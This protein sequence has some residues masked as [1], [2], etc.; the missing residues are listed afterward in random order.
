MRFERWL[1]TFVGRKDVA[2]DVVDLAADDI[3]DKL[4]EI[5]PWATDEE[6]REEFQ[7][8]LT[9]RRYHNWKARRKSGSYHG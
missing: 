3:L 5:C 1:T 9:L 8:I 4:R 2:D 6:V 7:R